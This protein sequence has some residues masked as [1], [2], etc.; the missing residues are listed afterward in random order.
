MLWSEVAF[1]SAQDGPKPP[2]TPPASKF[3]FAKFCPER[4]RSSG[5]SKGKIAVFYAYNPAILR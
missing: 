5:A 3:R 2:A 4:A 1:D